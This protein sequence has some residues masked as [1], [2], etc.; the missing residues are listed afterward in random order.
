MHP[1]PPA[2]HF[3]Q[4]FANGQSQAQSAESA[5]RG[6]LGLLEL[7]ENALL[8]ARW[9]AQAGILDGNHHK[10]AQGIGAQNDFAL[11]GKFDRIIQQVQDNLA[12][13]RAVR[14]YQG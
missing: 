5:G 13:A 14:E 1:D 8:L 6:A 9:D 3:D 12:Q 7:F 11:V 4:A 2:V 10:P